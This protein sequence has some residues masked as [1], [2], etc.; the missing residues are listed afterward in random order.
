VLLQDAS[1]L[2]G[3][4]VDLRAGA[5]QREIGLI[6]HLRFAVFRFGASQY[7]NE[8]S[9]LIPDE[10]ILDKINAQ[11]LHTSSGRHSTEQLILHNKDIDRITPQLLDEGP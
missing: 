9:Q 4:Q 3:Q 10:A 6:L 2:S 5:S 11:I 1:V 7:E 8:T